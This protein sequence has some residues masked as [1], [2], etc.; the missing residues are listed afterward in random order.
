MSATCDGRGKDTSHELGCSENPCHSQMQSRHI[1]SLP[2]AQQ[3]LY[4]VCEQG[5]YDSRVLKKQHQ[6]VHSLESKCLKVF[7][8]AKSKL[9]QVVSRRHTQRIL[10]ISNNKRV[11][12]LL[13]CTPMLKHG[14]ENS[15]IVYDNK[16]QWLWSALL[17]YMF[18][19]TCTSTRFDVLQWRICQ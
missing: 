19:N 4:Q 16:R 10:A 17:N 11:L 2:L 7:M 8:S 9:P 12:L 14:H 5:S 13:R 15:T 3:L 6:R 18:I 1:S